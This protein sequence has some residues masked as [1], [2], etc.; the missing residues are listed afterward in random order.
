MMAD[1]FEPD[2]RDALQEVVNVGMGTAAAALG[3]VLESFVSLSVPRI[4]FVRLEQ[5]DDLA[6]LSGW[7][8]DAGC[9]IR[10]AFYDQLEGEVIVLFGSEGQAQLSHKLGYDGELSSAG[11]QEPLL[12]FSNVL[13]GACMNGVGQQL[14]LDLSFSPPSVLCVNRPVATALASLTL[15]V[16]Y[17]LLINVQFVLQDGSFKSQLLI[18]LPEASILVLKGAV[19]RFVESL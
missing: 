17:A 1:V 11:D 15:A 5:L 9:A 4:E 19:E 10:Q 7:K 6:A 14:H 3:A 18:L 16:S 12:D 8:D 13:V 2:Q